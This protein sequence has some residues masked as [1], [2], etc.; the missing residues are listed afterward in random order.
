MG[1]YKMFQS[2]LFQSKFH[3]DELSQSIIEY[4][5]EECKIYK[6]VDTIVCLSESTIGILR[7]IYNLRE[8]KI[9]L[10]PNGIE[11]HYPVNRKTLKISTRKKLG[12]SQDIKLGIFVG[13]MVRSK[14][15]ESL[16][17]ALLEIQHEAPNFMCVLIGPIDGIMS[18]KMELCQLSG[19]IILTNVLDQKELNDWYM[20]ADIGIL[21]SYSEQCS[22]VAIEMMQHNL[23]IVSSDC[24]GL[25]DMFSNENAIIA[26]IGSLSN[27]DFYVNNLKK[28]ILQAINLTSQERNSKLIK[29]KQLKYRYSLKQM[30]NM[31]S[32]LFLKLIAER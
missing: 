24:I 3:Q 19:K 16:L 12:I 18:Y 9:A 28:S 32:R 23:S 10:I 25:R 15:I 2:F 31:Y 17:K 1:Q 14:G 13:R 6:I 5:E 4:F 11:Y 8:D 26:H 21:P 7:D 27:P 30:R 20:A 29:L 22:Y